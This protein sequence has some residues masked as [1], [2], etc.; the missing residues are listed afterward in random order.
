M[1]YVSI[2]YRSVY[3]TTSRQASN[4]TV[5]DLTRWSRRFGKL[6]QGR[7]GRPRLGAS[8]LGHALQTAVGTHRF[9]DIVLVKGERL[10]VDQ[11]ETLTGTRA[12]DFGHLEAAGAAEQTNF[13]DFLLAFVG[14]HADSVRVDVGGATV[15]VDK[16]QTFLLALATQHNVV[17]VAAGV[18]TYEAGKHELLVRHGGLESVFL[19]KDKVGRGCC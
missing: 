15:L 14:D 11:A 13:A 10:H 4:L 16:A 7:R 8:H 12:Q 17:K 6:V 9:G 2:V 5:H 3:R 1:L 19:F 18:A